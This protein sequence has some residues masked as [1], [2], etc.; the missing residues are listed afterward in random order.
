MQTIFR[1]IM[2]TASRP[3]LIFEQGS[4]SWLTDH[5]G[6]QYLDFVQG[7]AVNTLG[8]C[9]A[10]ITNT[11]NQQSSRL[12]NASPAFYNRPMLECAEALTHHSVFDQVFFAN[13]GAEA[14]EGA[15][16][17][18]RK[19]GKVHKNGAWKI[20]TFDNSFHGRTLT[21]MAASGKPAFAPMFEPKT[22]GFTKVSFNEAEA[23]RQAIDT[24]TVAI[25]IE[26]IQGEAG[27][28]PATP[29]F[30]HTLRQLADEHN[31]LLICDEVQTGMGRTGDLFAYQGYGIVPDIMT[32]GKGLGGGVPISAL[33]A[34]HH[35]CVFTAGE[36][37]GTYNG[38][39]LMSAVA[40]SII[41][42]ITQPDFLST[43]RERSQLLRDALS[44]LSLQSGLGEIRG[45]GLLLALDTGTLD[46]VAIVQACFEQG[47]LI[48]T[49]QPHTLRF[50][51]ALN[52]T[53]TEIKQ[54]TTILSAVLST[55]CL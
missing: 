40:Y 2:Q 17:L 14:N 25:M 52:V 19:W 29:E 23:V 13:S 53:E 20:I 9:P 50:M 6:K 38:N 39:P 45:R 43:V 16:K 26:P 1:N 8:H 11:L 28:I 30:L 35:A 18:A 12:I 54:M 5:N 47:L 3:E 22:P 55:N 31:L 42:A 33:L 10:V 4:G 24:E 37:G 49:P 41:Q 44:S 48:N 32:L 51:P 46:A 15:I 21:T 27:V 36:Q 7:W 34:K